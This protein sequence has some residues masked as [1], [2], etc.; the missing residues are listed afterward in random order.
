MA[1]R[2]AELNRVNSDLVNVQT[3]TQQGILLLS[4]NFAIRRFTAQ[5]AKQFNLLAADIG[6]PLSSVRHNLD[7]SDLDRFITE[8]IDSVRPG[9]REVQ[10]KDGRWF[11]LRV[12]P[13]V[14][15]DN[16]VDG[17]VLVLVDISDLK[18]K[19]LSIAAAR[20]YAEAIL[21]AAPDPL[22]ILHADLRVDTANK[23]FYDTFQVSPTDATGRLLYELGNHQ[24]D[25]PR[26]R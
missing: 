11:S 3:S 25:I 2:N 4:R 14:T 26:L 19:E 24:W 12:R 6:R 13:Y 17:A 5:A 22:L 20:D 9:E 16:K 23:A 8:V 18:R 21:R 7:V 10:D 15:L 1:N